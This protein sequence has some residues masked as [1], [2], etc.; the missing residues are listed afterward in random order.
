M[1][2]LI[3][4]LYL[5]D[6]I[7]SFFGWCYSW[8]LTDNKKKEEG[9]LKQRRKQKEAAQGDPEPKKGNQEKEKYPSPGVASWSC[10]ISMHQSI[11]LLE[12]EKN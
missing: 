4:N 2:S 1:A 10:F 5:L 9:G 7:G 6:L 8:D 3:D 12:G 11:K